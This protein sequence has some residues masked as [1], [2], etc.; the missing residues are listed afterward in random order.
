MLYRTCSLPALRQHLPACQ[1]D[2]LAGKVS[3]EILAGNPAIDNILPYQKGDDSWTITREQRRELRDNRY[4]VVLCT[5]VIRY[6]PDLLLGVALKIPNR[7][8]F[9]IKGLSGLVT[10][11]VA[12]DFPSPYPAYIRTMVATVTGTEGNWPLLPR[13]YPTAQDVASAEQLWSESGLGARPVVAC[14]I[15]T[16]QPGGWP[17]QHFLRALKAISRR[18]DADFVLFGAADEREIL[19]DAARECALPCHLLAGTLSLRALTAYLAK[20]SAVL[21]LDSGPRHLANAARVPVV[22]GRNLT[23]R[24]IETGK[25]CD[26]EIDASPP[27]EFVPPGDVA[28]VV[29]R[30][31]PER[32]A[33]LVIQAMERRQ[34]TD[35]SWP[36]A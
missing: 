29:S 24:A 4:D 22:F 26:N 23:V 10:L 34:A 18:V 17:R 6:F 13:V 32:T 21:A 3:A 14:S 33:S 11:P 30:L 1:W 19:A 27:D 2:Y 36:F 25:Y 31:D 12:V 35:V 28:S 9:T 5:N 7:V 20:C 16:R 8:A 15:T